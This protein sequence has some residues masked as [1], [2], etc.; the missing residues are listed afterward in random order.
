MATQRKEMKMG[1]KHYSHCV[2]PICQKMGGEHYSHCVC[3]NCQ[4]MGGA[5]YS[6]CVCPVCQRM[7]GEHYFHCVALNVK[8][9]GK[10]NVSDLQLEADLV[11]RQNVSCW[12]R[13]SCRSAA[14]F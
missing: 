13:A 8:G 3:P 2:C 9:W 4:K 11:R 1:G 6:H 10:S 7:G 14:R 12:V 5:H